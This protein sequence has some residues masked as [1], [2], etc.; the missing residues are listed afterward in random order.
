[1][2]LL[3]IPSHAGGNQ[4]AARQLQIINE[5]K[6]VSRAVACLGSPNT[7]TVRAAAAALAAITNANAEASLL[8]LHQ[9]GAVPAALDLLA[10]KPVKKCA[11]SDADKRAAGAVGM[12]FPGCMKL[13]LSS[14]GV[15]P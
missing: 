14:A 11:A 7:D 9:E 4:A 12:R 5:P 13:L 6:F 1:M 15:L 8:V 10:S 3:H 2:Y